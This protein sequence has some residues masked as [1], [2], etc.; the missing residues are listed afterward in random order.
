[1][2][3]DRNWTDIYSAIYFNYSHYCL[4]RL[5]LREGIP[6][7]EYYFSK[8]N[9]RLGAWHSGEMVYTFGVIPEGSKLYDASDYEVEAEMHRAW[10]NFAAGGDPNGEGVPA[11][12]QSTGDGVLMEF[13]ESTGPVE[14]PMLP[15]YE[16]LDEMQG[17]Q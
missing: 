10:V 12:A 7:W 14:E 3:A 13:G 5:A 6:V 1:E 17:W 15:L 8:D 16:I 9:G 4:N 2:E 11:F